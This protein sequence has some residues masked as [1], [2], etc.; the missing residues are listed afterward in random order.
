MPQVGT[1][2]HNSRRGGRM[3]AIVFDFD[4]ETLKQL[5]P[6]SSWNNAYADVRN[7]LT[8]RG[9]EW[10]QGSAYFGD[11]TVDAVRCVRIVQRLSRRY[12]WFKP[13]VRDIRMLR[14]EENNDLT[15]ALDDED[16]D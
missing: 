9:F 5:Y 7:Y 16:E 12:P 10:K 11:E 6:S 14:I 8:S 13:S 4:T 1:I 3:Y 15:I 2:G